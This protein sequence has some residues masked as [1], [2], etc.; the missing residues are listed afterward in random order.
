ML[1]RAQAFRAGMLSILR[2]IRRGRG[3]FLEA[4]R[5]TSS[6]ISSDVR[7]TEE[8]GS[9]TFSRDSRDRY[10]IRAIGDHFSDRG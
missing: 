9:K 1:L 8:A 6:G 5:L 3:D 4:Q 10:G 2:P 7:A